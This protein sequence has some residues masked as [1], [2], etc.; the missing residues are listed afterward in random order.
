MESMGFTKRHMGVII[1]EVVVS[2]SVGVNGRI[3]RCF[4][5]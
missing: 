2:L 5:A 4:L 1:L 3:S